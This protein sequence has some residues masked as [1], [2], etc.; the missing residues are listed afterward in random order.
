MFVP[1]GKPADGRGLRALAGYIKSFP[2]SPSAAE[3][4]YAL[5]RASLARATRLKKNAA[6]LRRK[7]ADYLK[8]AIDHEHLGLHSRQNGDHRACRAQDA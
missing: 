3:I 5:G 2:E 7:A 4:H 1:P 8:R 6:V